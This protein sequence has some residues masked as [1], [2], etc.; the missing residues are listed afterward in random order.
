MKKHVFFTSLILTILIFSTAMVV[1]YSLDFFRLGSILGVMNEHE[2]S[3][4]AYF[5]QEDFIETF[6]GDKCRALNSKIEFLKEETKKV[7]T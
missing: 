3:S 6:G 1:N 5:V 7:G 2:I 4:E